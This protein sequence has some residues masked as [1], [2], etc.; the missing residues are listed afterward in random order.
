MKVI[1]RN[2]QSRPVLS[3]GRLA[4]MACVV[5]EHLAA[6]PGAF[7]IAFVD[8]STMSEHHQRFRGQSRTTD[9]LAFPNELDRIVGGGPGPDAE[10]EMTP[11]WGDVI[12]C[13]DQAVR[14]ARD[15]GHPYELEL[16][17][18]AI[19]GSLHLLG[20][21]HTSDGGEMTRLEE[22]LRPR[23]WAAGRLP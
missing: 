16:A 23:C 4:A 9:V 21:D 5:R 7:G 18:L 20:F 12:V 2:L 3:P 11:Y 14:Q 22:A 17:I 1:V 8:D 10:D 6:E 19:H 15:L 13:A